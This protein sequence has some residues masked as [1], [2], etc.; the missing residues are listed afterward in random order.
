MLSFNFLVFFFWNF[1]NSGT[2]L[3]I[4]M[5]KLTSSQVPSSKETW[6]LTNGWRTASVA[7]L[8]GSGHVMMSLSS[9]EIV[10][11][12]RSMLQKT[13]V[14]TW[15]LIRSPKRRCFVAFVTFKMASKKKGPD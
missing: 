9:S 13:V 2:L 10:A 14:P 15:N 3:S 5:S 11:Y 1:L 4:D 7:G 12:K 6:P 8:I